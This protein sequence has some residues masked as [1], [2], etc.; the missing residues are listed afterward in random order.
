MNDETRGSQCPEVKHHDCENDQLLV[1]TESVLYKLLQLDPYRAMEHAGIHTRILKK[2]AD[3][4]A[5][6]L[7]SDF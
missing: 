5:K 7:S 1:D 6:L 4:I 3:V 2:L